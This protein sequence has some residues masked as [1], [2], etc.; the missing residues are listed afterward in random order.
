MQRYQQT[1]ADAIWQTEGRAPYLADTSRS[2]P[3]S[4]RPYRGN[5]EATPT[6]A[7]PTVEI[8]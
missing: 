2:T 8:R 6:P 7:V 3:E 1:L 5:S 4:Q